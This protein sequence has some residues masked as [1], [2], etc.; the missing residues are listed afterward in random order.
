[1]SANHKPQKGTPPPLEPLTA[2]ARREARRQR[3]AKGE[4]AAYYRSLALLGTLGW[5]IVAPL[6]LGLFG[7][8]WLDRLTGTGI[9]WTLGGATAGLAFGGWIAWRKLVEVEEEE[10]RMEE[11]ARGED[12]DKDET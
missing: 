3:L 2:P 12:E 9:T 6:L 4:K 11:A 5:L 8:R 1:M 7:G 10:R